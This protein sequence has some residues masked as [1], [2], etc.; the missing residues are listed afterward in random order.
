[1]LTRKQLDYLALKNIVE[2]KARGSHKT[3][4]GLTLIKNN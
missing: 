3:L 1:M 2:L 4:E